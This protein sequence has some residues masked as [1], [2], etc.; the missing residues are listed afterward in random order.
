M[1][2]TCRHLRAA[3][4]MPQSRLSQ[5]MLAR[6]YL[7]LDEHYCILSCQYIPHSLSVSKVT[8]LC[9]SIKCYWKEKT[10]LSIPPPTIS[11]SLFVRVHASCPLSAADSFSSLPLIFYAISNSSSLPSFYLLAL[12]HSLSFPP[13]NIHFLTTTAKRTNRRSIAPDA[14]PRGGPRRK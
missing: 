14:I 5:K 4:R 10:F 8:P 12:S 2:S 6:W 1:I 9:K 3:E 11:V 13:H 7:N